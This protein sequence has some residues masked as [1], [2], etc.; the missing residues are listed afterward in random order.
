MTTC[1]EKGI[2]EKK[3]LVMPHNM[4]FKVLLKS[5]KMQHSFSGFFNDIICCD[6][7]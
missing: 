7:S 1:N 5:P 3:H 2:D 4:Q 6:C